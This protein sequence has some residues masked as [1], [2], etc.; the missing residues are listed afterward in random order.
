MA[1]VEGILNGRPLTLN[2]DSSI[3]TEP[4]TPNHLLLLCPNLN[5][6]PG[7]FKKNDLYCQHRW[8]QVQYLANVFWKRWISEN[9]PSLRER[10]KWIKPLRKSSSWPMAPRSHSQSSPRKGQICPI[11]HDQGCHKVVC[12]DKANFKIV[13]PRTR[14]LTFSEEL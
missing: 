11:S 13:F 12:I 6:P 2:S 9:L 5:F 10:P 7:T 1:E 14:E 3:N 4:L 8:K